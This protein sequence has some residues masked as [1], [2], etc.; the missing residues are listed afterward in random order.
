MEY[1]NRQAVAVAVACAKEY[2]QKLANTK[3]LIIYRDRT[4]MIFVT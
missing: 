3:L 4:A 1:T 2:K